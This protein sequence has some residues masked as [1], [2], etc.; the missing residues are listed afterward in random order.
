MNPDSL[1]SRLFS[2]SALFIRTLCTNRN[3]CMLSHMANV[4]EEVDF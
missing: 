4:T 1:D 2:V 3:V